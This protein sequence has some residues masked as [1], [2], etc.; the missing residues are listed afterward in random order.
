M[1]G[2]ISIDKPQP[3]DLRVKLRK[4]MVDHYIEISLWLG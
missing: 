4:M 1:Q 2:A 3:N